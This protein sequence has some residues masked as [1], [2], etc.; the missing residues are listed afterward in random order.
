[1]DQDAPKLPAPPSSPTDVALSVDAKT[2]TPARGPRRVD[3]QV[4]RAL[5]VTVVVLFHLGVP[6]FSG[7]FVGVDVFFVVSGYLVYGSLLRET[8]SGAFSPAA[9]LARRMKRLS[10]PS[11]VALTVLAAALLAR[12]S[13][14]R[15]V[16]AAGRMFDDVRAAA[17][18][19]ANVHFLRGATAYFADTAP[20]VVLHYWSLA[21]EEQLYV[22]IPLLAVPALWPFRG[23][24]YAAAALALLAATSAAS[25]A[26]IAVQPQPTKFFAI[27]ARYWEFAA[28]AAVAR[29][30]RW[31]PARTGRLLASYAGS[32]G[33]LVVA[34]VVARGDSWPNALTVAVCGLTAYVIACK[35]EYKAPGLETLGNMSYSVYLYHWPVIQFVREYYGAPEGGP[36]TVQMIAVSVAVFLVL[37]ALSYNLVELPVQR[38]RW[39]GRTTFAVFCCATI[40]PAVLAYHG[41]VN[42]SWAARQNNLLSELYMMTW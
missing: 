35:L 36:M 6:G 17:L 5:A 10:L 21:V 29:L 38:A 27:P 8:E 40:I 19:Y 33:L 34:S 28:G 26:L 24:R 37:A 1:M 3:I 7:G 30:D 11:A 18:H 23:P 22:A 13:S 16:V 39:S 14:P 41:S 42:M 25:L 20:S 12:G 2:P 15:S 32:V 31:R 4:L 9:F